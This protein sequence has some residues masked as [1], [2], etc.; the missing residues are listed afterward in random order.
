MIKHNEESYLKLKNEYDDSENKPSSFWHQY[1]NDICNEIEKNGFKNY[2]TSY[3]LT[4]GGFGDTPKITPRPLLR[5]IFKIPLIY[6][7][8]EKKYVYFVLDRVKKNFYNNLS[9]DQFAKMDLLIHLSKK[10]NIKTINSKVVRKILVEGNQIP[11]SYTKGAIYLD[12]IEKIID[13]YNLKID[14]NNLFNS[15]IIDIGGGI[16][17][18]LHC[19]FEFNK[20][21]NFNKKA[22]FILL[23]QFPVSYIAK[24]NL[25]YF[26]ENKVSILSDN[27][28]LINGS[29]MY[30]LQNT[31]SSK[32]TNLNISFYFNSSSFQEMEEYQVLDYCKF[33]ENNAAE[34]SYLASFLYP[35]NNDLNSDKAI[36]KILSNKFN[37]LGWDK[38]Y[39]DKY[40]GGTSG[41]LYLYKI[42]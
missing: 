33:I 37:L 39:F 10:L 4:Y 16:G 35:S 7:Y 19:Y 38:N 1:V 3:K 2:G 17:S 8:F 23:D 20:I 18:I 15:N 29:K 14:F 26:T 9:K 30:V 42:R 6:K 12:I 41:I 36:L 5:K 11:H 21:N 28:S 13:F 24:Q 27:N 34:E 22:L 31:T 40:Q 25:E 32:L